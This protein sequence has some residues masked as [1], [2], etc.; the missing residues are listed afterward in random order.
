MPV[1]HALGSAEQFVPAH[2]RSP[3]L[4]RC[5]AANSLS[6]IGA[7]QGIRST[8]I[9]PLPWDALTKIQNSCGEGISGYRNDDPAVSERGGVRNQALARISGRI[10]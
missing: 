9:W 1:R 5:A 8:D 6:E 10:R 2:Y 7:L 3:P 4:K